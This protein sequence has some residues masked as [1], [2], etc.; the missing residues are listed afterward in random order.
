MINGAPA[1][2][3][4]MCLNEQ[5]WHDHIFMRNNCATVSSIIHTFLFKANFVVV[6]AQNNLPQHLMLVLT[7]VHRPHVCV[8]VS[9]FLWQEIV[10]VVFFG[11]EYFVRLWS[12]GCRSKYVGISGRLRFA[13]KPISIIGRKTTSIYAHICIHAQKQVY[14]SSTHKQ[15][16]NSNSNISWASS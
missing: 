10:L 15:Y 6:V 1:G 12:A 16:L 8:L 14:H 5:Q 7:P 13:R 9:P 3:E 2:W 4:S 11:V